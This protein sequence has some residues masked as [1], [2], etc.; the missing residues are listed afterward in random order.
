MKY[1]RFSSEGFPL[2]FYADDV[3]ASPTD[4]CIEISDEQWQFF[5]DNQGRSRWN[6]TDVE[7]YTPSAPIPTEEDNKT[8]ALQRLQSTDWVNGADVYDTS[9]NPHLLNRDEFLVY[10][11]WCRNIAVNPVAG[12]LD[13]PTEPVASWN[14][15]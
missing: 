8:Y 12:N 1:A 3:G 13:W 5:L 10:R 4:D 6:G 11:S 2:A 14:Q 9:R 7:P 15:A